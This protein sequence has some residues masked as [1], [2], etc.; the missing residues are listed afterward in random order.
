MSLPL[1]GSAQTLDWLVSS[2]DDHTD[3]AMAVAT[4]PVSGFV[5]V[6][7]KISTN[8]GEAI[9]LFDASLS[10]DI[11][12]VNTEL[13]GYGGEDA[14]L[15]CFND[16]G[17]LQWVQN[18][19]SAEDDEILDVTVAP[20]GRVIVTGRYHDSFALTN[21][22]DGLGINF[23]SSDGGSECD[24]FII[25]FNAFGQAEWGRSEGGD[26]SD[27]GISLAANENQVV[28]IGQYRNQDATIAGIIPA[29][30]T[31]SNDIFIASYQLDGTPMWLATAGTEIDDLDNNNSFQE[32]TWKIEEYQGSFYIL[33]T[34][35]GTTLEFYDAA[36]N[37]D[38]TKTL[39]SVDNDADLF[40]ARITDSGLFA[41]TQPII[42]TSSDVCG[43]GLDVGCH[44]LFMTAASQV[45]FSEPVYLPS[46]WVLDD[47]DGMEVFITKHDRDTGV[48][49]WD[50]TIDY[51]G[52]D[53]LNST[54]LTVHQDGYVYVAGSFDSALWF[55][56]VYDIQATSNKDG[57]LAKFSKDLGFL[58][59]TS[60]GG[61]GDDQVNDLN[62]LNEQLLFAGVGST[63]LGGIAVFDGAQNS[64][65]GGMSFANTMQWPCCAGPLGGTASPAST[66]L[67]LGE[68]VTIS[69][70]G[71]SGNDIQWWK[72]Y[73]YGDTW[74]IIDG[75]TADNFSVWPVVD[76]VFKAQVTNACGE[77]YST[78][79]F[80][81]VYELDC[82]A[83][84]EASVDDNCEYTIPDYTSVVIPDA[85]PGL[86]VVQFPAAGTVVNTGVVSV[87]M[88]SD[89]LATK[90]CEF[91]LTV[92]DDIAPTVDCPNDA[93]RSANANCEFILGDVAD[94]A[95]ISDNCEYSTSQVPVI[96]TALGLGDHTIT[97]KVQ[98]DAGNITNCTFTLTIVDS[99]API[100][101]CP[102]DQNEDADDDCEFIIPDYTTILLS[103][104]D[105]CGGY[106]LT[107]APVA[108]TVVNAGDHTITLTATDDAGNA[109]DCDFTLTV[110]DVTDPDIV[111]PGDQ[112]L[113]STGGCQALLPDYTGLALASDA[114][115]VPNIVQIP[116]PGTIVTG[117]LTV[118]LVAR[119]GALNN[120]NCQF[121]VDFQV[122]GPPAINCPGN[123]TLSPNGLCQHIL[124]DYTTLASASDECEDFA[125][126]Q[127][128]A[129][130]TIIN[131]TTTITM[132]AT[133]NE[134]DVST[135]NFQVIPLIPIGLGSLACPG[136]QTISFD[137]FCN[138]TLPDYTDDIIVAN[139][140][141]GFLVDQSPAA[142]T[143]ITEQT[144]VTITVT[145][146]FVTLDC[147]FEVTPEDI[148]DPV[149][150]CPGN[151]AVVPN[152]SCQYI[153]PDVT[154]MA[155]ASDNCD[156]D[157]TIS[158]SPA[159]GTPMGGFSSI[160]VTAT[161]DAGNSSDCT[162]NLLQVMPIYNPQVTCPGDW[163]ASFDADCE[164]E[165]SD[166]TDLASASGFCMSTLTMTQ[167][168]PDGTVITTQTTITITGED[169][170]GNT[171]SCQFDIIPE[172]NTDP[173]VWCI[174]DQSATLSPTCEVILADYTTLIMANDNCDADLTMVQNPAPGAVI[175]D[176]TAVTISVAD[177]AGNT[178]WCNFNVSLVDNTVPSI[179]C[180]G[181]LHKDMNVDCEYELEDLTGLVVAVDCGGSVTVTQSPIPGTLL[182][183][184]TTITFE[185][186]D[187]DGNTASCEMDIH[188]DDVIDPVISCPGD[189]T[190]AVDCSFILPDYTSSGVASDCGLVTISQSPAVGT[191]IW[192]NTQITLTAQDEAGNEST[193]SFWVYLEDN[194]APVVECPDPLTVA[195]SATCQYT[196]ADFTGSV[197]ILHDCSP[198]TVTQS[199]VAGTVFGLGDYV[200]ELKAE[201]AHGNFVIC[202]LNLTVADQQA[203]VAVCVSSVQK[204]AND[205]CQYV[206]EDLIDIVGVTENCG[207]SIYQDPVAGTVLEQGLT[208][209][210]FTVDDPSGNSTT[211][212]TNLL[213]ID[214]TAP[215]I[216]CPA[217][218][219]KPAN[220]DCKYTMEDLSGEISYTENCDMVTI[221]QVPAPGSTVVGST[222]V[223]MT[224]MDQS[225][226]ITEC[227]FELYVEDLEDPTIVCPASP[228]VDIANADCELATPD[229]SASL[230]YSDNCGIQSFTQT[231]LAGTILAPGVHEINIEL[232]DL[233]GN[234]T[235]CTFD[236]EVVDDNWP[237]LDCPDDMIVETDATCTYTMPDFELSTNP[238]DN[239]GI[240][241]FNQTPIAGTELSPGDYV[242]TLTIEDINGNESV[243]QFDLEVQQ[244]TSAQLF[245]PDTQYEITGSNCQ[246]QL[247]DYTSLAT[248]VNCAGSTVD[249][250]ITQSPPPGFTFS[251]L[252]VVTLTFTDE[253]GAAISCDFNVECVDIDPPVMACPDV[254]VII[255]VDTDCQGIVADYTAMIAATDNCDDDPVI[256]Q[257]PLEGT[258][259]P[260]GDHD[261]WIYAQDYFGNIDSCSVSIEVIDQID[262]IIDCPG[263][264]LASVGEDCT[265][266][267]EDLTGL[268]EATDNCSGVTVN[269][270]IPPGVNYGP[271]SHDV[272]FVVND[273]NGN[274]ANCTIE[275]LVNDGNSPQ[276]TSCPGEQ[277]IDAD[278]DCGYLMPDFTG[279]LEATDNCD[280]DLT[281][282]QTPL[283][284]T[285]QSGPVSVTLTVLDDHGNSATCEFDLIVSDNTAPVVDCPTEIFVV[286]LDDNCQAT[287]PDFTAF[288]LATDN[289]SGDLTIS[290][291]PPAGTLLDA[292]LSDLVFIVEDAAGNSTPCLNQV[293]VVDT[294]AP[295]VV[296]CNQMVEVA[297][298]DDC[299]YILEDLT[300]LVQ[301]TDNCS[302]VTITQS[303]ASGTEL[304][305]AD[306][307]INFEIEDEA[308]NMT[309]C[310]LG[311]TVSDQTAPQIIECPG[312]QLVNADEDCGY[313]LADYTS[314]LVATD[315]CDE[316]LS[317]TQNP[318]AGNYH[319]GP[320]EVTLEVTDA[321]GNSAECSFIVGV[322]DDTPPSILCIA[323]IEPVAVNDD[324]VFVLP[325]YTNSPSVDD[326]CGGEI[327]MT[328]VPEAG[329]ELGLGNHEV[330]VIA[331]DLMGNADS[332]LINIE[333]EDQTTPFANGIDTDI[334]LIIGPD[335]LAEMADLMELWGVT[336]NCDTDLD[337]VQSPEVGTELEIGS[338]PGFITVT[339]D[340]DN[341]FIQAFT[342]NVV[343]DQAP[344][345]SCPE[346]QT[347]LLDG[348][349]TASVPDY[350]SLVTAFDCSDYSIS[351][352][353]PA[354][355]EV[356]ESFIVEITVTDDSGSE[357]I[358]EFDVTLSDQEDPVVDCLDDQI[359]YVDE[360]CNTQLGDFTGMTA[361]SDNCEIASVEQFPEP[362]SEFEIGS[363]ND[364]Q[365]VVTDVYG[366]TGI[367]E[368]IVTYIDEIAPVVDCPEDIVVS[369]ESGCSAIVEFASPAASDNCAQLT[370]IQLQGLASGEEFPIGITTQEFQMI[371]GSG[372]ETTC[373]F[374]ITVLDEIDPIIECI[375]PIVSCDPIITYDIPLATDNC[376]GV[377]V[378]Q[379]DDT[380][381]TSGSEFPTGVTTLMF[382][383]TDASGNQTTCIVQVTVLEEIE[384]AWGPL[385]EVI[386]QNTDPIEL[387]D[388]A[389]QFDVLSWSAPFDNGWITPADLS[390]G[391]YEITLNI[392]VNGCESDSTL[393]FLLAELPGVEAGD[394]QEV[395]G[396]EAMLEGISSADQ[397]QWDGAASYNPA[398]N[399]LDVLVGEEDYGTHTYTLTAISADG[400]VNS[401]IVSVNYY[402]MPNM[403]DAGHDQTL[404]FIY[405]TFL[406][407]EYSG[408]GS[409]DWH[410]VIETSFI[411]N[412]NNPGSLVT[413]LNEGDN[414][415]ILVASNGVCPSLSDTVTVTVNG[416]LIPTGFS[417]NGDNVN[418]MFVIKGL[419]NWTND[420]L[421]VFN[422][423]GNKVYENAPY[424]N[425]WDGRGKNDQALPNDTYYFTLRI[426]DEEHKGYVIIKR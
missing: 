279:L 41:W 301:A 148:D 229:F 121:D 268:I 339:D 217:S 364:I 399:V 366:N 84:L 226:N 238:T 265:Y 200:I 213:V 58:A 363:E 260:L 335:C 118:T 206:L 299:T 225:G 326:N 91:D 239:C 288:I 320:V 425:S 388:L 55:D 393:S 341:Q 416:L 368:F 68:G 370:T 227:E 231:P 214:N 323:L 78:K 304:G 208:T 70:S 190:E 255:D 376:D 184:T 423:W 350:S 378:D 221:T 191:E 421:T 257:S 254:V 220:N 404:D 414:E 171:A 168:P 203:P 50:Y 192:T 240:A 392:E 258:T 77:A 87:A 327:I 101:A 104:G 164:Y 59:G 133:D 267:L 57:F 252:Q 105:N 83:S 405:E 324:C 157:L 207:Y 132:T 232:K 181:D 409:V 331:E 76:M 47:G 235:L 233:S 295:L 400:C 351:Q 74:T 374:T 107:Q 66:N 398:D 72:S 63:G 322:T 75:A 110:N 359:I 315:N 126:V 124:G 95:T 17:V 186:E 180:P 312:D 274:S 170:F 116:A 127:T 102:G 348:N 1:L 179:I 284:G 415:F 52:A 273:E 138:A 381:L 178:S 143:A 278:N 129:P 169:A 98:D 424:D 297:V 306:H 193:C 149:I 151:T 410:Q 343:D 33:A 189:Q 272:L 28:L 25:C 128:P 10:N 31:G 64:F 358:C 342:V 188:V 8:Q 112:V 6:G 19:G 67:C 161:D 256:W 407:G 426:D 250:P 89:D 237:V 80:V 325:D 36:N 317:V 204:D 51:S 413:S 12:I 144:T 103:A 202:N 82:P 146:L 16:E 253:F 261:V 303:P 353:P 18:F 285:E 319:D 44:G 141:A 22:T 113:E 377:V 347:L 387:L 42:I 385:P 314:G 163:P 9:N 183:T 384:A 328:Q 337:I 53:N 318:I 137:G 174:S 418:D 402:E 108:G 215:D 386:C 62:M 20:D 109:S 212:S 406:E 92:I 316:A 422:R 100:F 2:S 394:N 355:T 420:G 334:E 228:I 21:T 391:S 383:A 54:S 65:A 7:G 354:G 367:C 223:T 96:G 99:T 48:D 93:T 270:M 360:S 3:M 209:V 287:M 412:P 276:I 94:Y 259:L 71:Y 134:G 291:F 198:V 344:E 296:E 263:T 365:I 38:A 333:V 160:T 305:I 136:D 29:Q 361:Y 269:Q 90:Y 139:L 419:E 60:I 275:V 130:G 247:G 308:G 375:E 403:P 290:Q 293:E 329:T 292:G 277:S 73:D 122:P 79:A 294:T 222:T 85:C 244:A 264:Y 69:L 115:V 49:T 176:P 362:G 162:I 389:G 373:E 349:C 248:A 417:P 177:D 379:T 175:T 154:G 230:E 313:I 39:S 289:C 249:V 35:Y 218:L 251:G 298:N 369:I 119:D 352:A 205:N 145:S 140:C 11:S 336:D 201:D 5:Y 182:T 166:Y 111:C 61:L 159:A 236:L 345:I 397:V 357:S 158:Q 14:Y 243:C 156:T 199:P 372:N 219:T 123:Q 135:C 346:D 120:R 282:N 197:N 187:E 114:C 266:S 390:P 106:T 224:V 196:L 23:I 395:C 4:D 242:V 310:S 165:I 262:P 167:S 302:E 210:T 356:T 241:S 245:C 150:T 216:S 173:V 32:L 45:T 26:K 211:C 152:G 131:G 401:D 195:A 142:G 307:T 15:A 281:V 97:L 246:A 340:F 46:G 194:N 172:D 81:D 411:V 300:S 332:C 380:G 311:L 321:A 330:W 37:A 117:D 371:D 43:I 40:L 234:T 309:P 56:G 286:D 88:W 155:T 30:N 382:T 280:D 338:H 24:A 13:I 27:V 86:D 34:Y 147:S 396:L 153:I 125:V 283:P 408:P 185:A 271:G